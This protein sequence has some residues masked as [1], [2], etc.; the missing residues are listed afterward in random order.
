MNAATYSCAPQGREG[1]ERLLHSP[2]GVK[3]GGLEFREPT[4]ERRIG[5]VVRDDEGRPVGALIGLVLQRL[6]GRG[7]R[8]V[9]RSSASF[10]DVLQVMAP[11]QEPPLHL[12]TAGVKHFR[13][14]A[15]PSRTGCRG[16]S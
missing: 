8:G 14:R 12:V 16:C 11:T 4:A 7:G 3:D 10:L 15:E 9:A 2:A 6:G 1:G 5:R 13:V